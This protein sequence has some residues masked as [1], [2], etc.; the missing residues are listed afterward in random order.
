MDQNEIEKAIGKKR[1][2]IRVEE[3]NS[4]FLNRNLYADSV[5]R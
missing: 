4:G 1:G 3:K 5:Q 2:E